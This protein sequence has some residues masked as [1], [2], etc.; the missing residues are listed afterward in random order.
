MNWD[1]VKK[2]AD[3]VL[4]EGYILYP[5]HPSSVK[6]RKRFNFGVLVPPAYSEAQSGGEAST[7]RTECLVEGDAPRLEIRV[8]F[9]H[10]TSQQVGR[11]NPREPA[12]SGDGDLVFDPV[13]F[14][15]FDGQIHHSWQGAVDREVVV[16]GIDTRD[17]ASRSR[18]QAFVFGASHNSELLRDAAG[19][20]LGMLVHCQQKIQG[21]ITVLAVPLGGG[22]W[23]VRVDLRNTTPLPQPQVGSRDDCLLYAM[24]STHTI[25]G[26]SAGRFVSLLEPGESHAAAAALCENVGTWPVLVGADGDRDMMLSSPIILYDYPQ[27]APE[28]DFDFCDGTEID[29]MLALRVMT[30][31]DQEKRLMQSADPRANEI[32]RRTESLS[33]EDWMKLHGAIRGLRP[34][35]GARS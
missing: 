20:T 2:I 22:V 29:E 25:L 34:A 23:R 27:I 4:Y 30:L 13:P 28:S 7:M 17:H 1:Q 19:N 15:E 32:L 35:T 31:T 3:A 12:P 5:Y 16:A 21:D 26:V 18:H 14:L 33:A 9:L 8:R 6:N 24:A 11:L 10:L